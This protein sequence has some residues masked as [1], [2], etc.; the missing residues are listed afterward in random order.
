MGSPLN[1]AERAAVEGPQHAVTF[2]SPFEIGKYPV[3]FAE[4]DHFCVKTGRELPHDE[5]WG[6]GRRPVINVSWQDATDYCA[7]LGEQTGQAYRLPSEAEWEY[8]CRAGTKTPFW[9]GE[10]LSTDQPNYDGNYIYGTGRK[11]KY[12]EQ[13][14]LVD[15]FGR[16]PWG[17]HDMHG[18]LWEWCEDRW[19][20]NYHGAPNDG[21]AW[22]EGKSSGRVMR[23]GSWFDGPR[24][25]RSAYRKWDGPV[26]RFKFLGFRVSTVLT[27]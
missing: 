21:S 14:T 5:T 25:L 2:A 15:T 1:E 18:N 23:G 11:G 24:S 3:T 19:H 9:T 16:N 10:T 27:S 17:L 8:A 6:R 22:L 12:R 7:W 26:L 20:D 4:Y 13:T